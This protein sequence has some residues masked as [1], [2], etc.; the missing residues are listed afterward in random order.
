MSSTATRLWSTQVHRRR[1]TALVSLSFNI[2]STDPSRMLRNTLPRVAITSQE[3]ACATSKT[4]SPPR[5]SAATHHDRR[6]HNR[7]EGG[8]SSQGYR[9]SDGVVVC[10]RRNYR[11][12]TLIREKDCKKWLV[13]HTEATHVPVP[14]R[15]VPR[16]VGVHIT[17]GR[18]DSWLRTSASVSLQAEGGYVSPAPTSSG[19]RLRQHKQE[20]AASYETAA[21]TGS[22]CTS[23]E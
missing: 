14:L 2:S 10:L 17:W 7:L 19:R 23:Q 1:Y 16:V 20:L 18:R 4:W 3:A 15:T 22:A 6:I 21:S 12:R 13:T 11:K 9:P 5:A 8:N